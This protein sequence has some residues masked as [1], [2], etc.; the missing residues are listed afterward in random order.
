ML[1]ELIRIVQISI[2]ECQHSLE[3]LLKAFVH[4]QQQI[5]SRVKNIQQ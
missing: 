1:H 2:E 3:V 5:F 4:A